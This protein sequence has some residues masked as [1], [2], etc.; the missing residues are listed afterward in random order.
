MKAG[1]YHDMGDVRIENLPRPETPRD[2]LLVRV[3]TCG[4]CGTDVAKYRHR[5]VEPPAVLGHEVAGEILDV[6]PDVAGWRPGERVV[7]PHHIPCFVCAHCRH[8]NVSACAAFRPTNIHPGGFAEMIAVDGPS[9]RKGVLRLPDGMTFDRAALCESLACC[10]RAFKRSGMRPGDSMAVIG[11]GPVG[12]MHLLL[13][14]SMGAGTLIGLDVVPERLEAAR[15]FGV[16][17]ALDARDE[18]TA[19]RVAEATGGFGADVAMVCVGSAAAVESALRLVRRGGRVHVFAESPPG[20]QVVLD[21]N[22]AYYETTLTGTY[23]SAPE[24]Q[25]EALRLIEH[26]RVDPERLVTHRLPLDRLQE[27]FDLAVEGREAL[28]ILI[29]P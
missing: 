7:V 15:R 27:A 17:L 4:L 3:R 21:P 8:G 1:V 6:G 29:H 9:T 10:L 18:R 26:G 20:A 2:G 11:C 13:A 12:L 28:K 23:S 5:L 24:D 22:V 25:A 19:G 16:A 14:A